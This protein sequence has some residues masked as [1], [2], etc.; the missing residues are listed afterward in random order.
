MQDNRFDDFD[1][2]VRSM[3]E[4]AAEIPPRRVW[5]GVSARLD[6]AAAPVASPWGWMKWAGLT[7]AAAAAIA[8]GVFLPGTKDTSIPTNNHYQE[9]AMLAQAGESAAATAQA[10]TAADAPAQEAAPEKTVVRRSARKAVTEPAATQEPVTAGTQPVETAGPKDTGTRNDGPAAGTVRDNRVPDTDPF[11]ELTTEKPV[12]KAVR[13]PALY[14]QGAVG[15]NES[16]GRP[17]PPAARMAPGT[18]DD[19]SEQGT[20]SYGIPF[21]IGLGI[22]FYVAPRLSLGTGLDYSLLTRTFT[23]NYQG[24]SGSV[25]H[26]LQYL[27]VPLNLYY[28]IIDAEKIRFYAYG[29][30]ELEYCISNKYK[31]F[32]SP[33]IIRKYPVDK[34]Q[35]SV[36]AGL[37]VEFRLSQ[38]LGLYL[39]PGLQYYFPGNQ[40]KSIRTEK[41]L[42]VN[43]DAGLRLNF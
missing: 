28:D 6:A 17:L 26:T 34:L 25:A 13:R 10:V 37:G 18:S 2:R 24:T 20:S 21:T 30:G 11:A 41:P 12:R 43:F 38:H 32:A 8:L 4:D 27:G 9:Q 31:L 15:G 42:M 14:A 19:F 5:K 16:T 3:L 36:G 22:R 39:D 29:G 33:D 23:G 1:L 7:L 40:P 35:Y